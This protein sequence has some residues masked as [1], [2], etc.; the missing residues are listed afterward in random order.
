MML[1]HDRGVDTDLDVGHRGGFGITVEEHEGSPFAIERRAH[2]RDHPL[3]KCPAN[4]RLTNRRENPRACVPVGRSPTTLPTTR[5][6]TN[7]RPC[8]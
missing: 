1:G 6:G 8:L 4:G 5:T 3:L 2:S 7:G